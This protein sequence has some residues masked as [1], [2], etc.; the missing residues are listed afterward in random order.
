M[1]VIV[2]GCLALVALSIAAMRKRAELVIGIALGL[3]L[4]GLASV[5]APA[6]TLQSM[7]VWL[8]ALPFAVIALTLLVFGVLAWWWGTDR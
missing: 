5:G 7:P 3:L 4:A 8:P 1:L 2:A 6:V